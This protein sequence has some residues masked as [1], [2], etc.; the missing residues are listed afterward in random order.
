MVDDRMDEDACEA[1]RSCSVGTH[2]T[3][4]LCTA[5]AVGGMWIRDAWWLAE[6]DECDGTTGV[7]CGDV[8]GGQD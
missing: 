2:D 8:I 1:S 3:E 6:G 7:V 4:E 5:P